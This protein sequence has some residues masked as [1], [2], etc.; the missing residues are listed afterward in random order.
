M[1]DLT[2]FRTIVDA[3]AQLQAHNVVESR[4]YALQ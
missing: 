1:T 3:G 4:R 2:F